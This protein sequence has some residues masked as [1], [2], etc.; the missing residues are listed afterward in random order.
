MSDSHAAPGPRVQP[1][2]AVTAQMVAVVVIWGVNFSVSKWSLRQFPPL[3]FTALRFVIASIVL[4]AV[5]RWREGRIRPPAGAT[6][7]LAR[8]GLIGNSIYQIAFIIGLSR[9]TATNS[10]LILASMPALV[11]ALGAALGIERLRRRAAQG[12]A[13]ATLGVVLVVVARGVSFSAGTAAGDLVTVL[14]VACWAAFT[15]GVRQLKFSM[16]PLAITCW[17][18][19]LGTPV[20]IAA[21]LPSLLQT[22]WRAITLAGWGG[23]G[24]ASVM[25]LV[26]AYL[27]W[28][29]SVRTVGSNRT[30]VYA[31]ATP[32][33]AMAT[34]ALMLG[35]RPA[36]LQLAGA[37]A[38]VIGVLLSQR[39]GTELPPAA[40]PDAP[41]PAGGGE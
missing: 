25:S 23:L 11:A 17:T 38:I 41:S 13:L 14:A 7:P 19:V 1:R 8:L 3:G 9:T 32:L 30:A 21:G 10:A 28:N 16:S 27:L 36:A 37:G 26:V 20:L 5:L 6:W 2:R 31:C 33:V 24:F 4:L 29:A 35:E 34:A 18:M 40:R 39:V 12:L 15:L 22:D